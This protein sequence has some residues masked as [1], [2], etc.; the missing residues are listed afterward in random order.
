[1]DLATATPPELQAEF[2][3]L[4]GVLAVTANERQAI[5]EEIE[6]RARAVL[7]RER[8]TRLSPEEKAVLRI[9]LDQ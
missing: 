8:M 5:H 7:V 2:V 1:M 9:A 4:G 3:R 6:R